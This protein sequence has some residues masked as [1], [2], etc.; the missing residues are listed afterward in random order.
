ML[1]EQQA[2][3]QHWLLISLQIRLREDQL[4][5]LEVDRQKSGFKTGRE[6]TK[7][8]NGVQKGTVKVRSLQHSPHEHFH[9]SPLFDVPK[10]IPSSLN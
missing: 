9:C 8:L 6:R 4:L 7:L 1:V 2:S 5:K 10:L 3:S